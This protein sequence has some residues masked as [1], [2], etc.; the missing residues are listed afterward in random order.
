MPTGSPS[1]RAGP[2]TLSSVFDDA[3]HQLAPGNSASPA[4]AAAT[5]DG[6]LFSGNRHESVPRALFFDRRL[7]PLE[8]NAWQMFR[9]MLDRDGLT[10]FPTYEQLRPWL[11]SMPGAQASHETIARTLTLLRLLNQVQDVEKEIAIVDRLLKLEASTEMVSRF[12]GLTH[13]EIALRRDILGL[14]KRQ[15]RHP[16]LDEAQDSDLWQRWKKLTRERAVQMDDETSVL[17]VAMDLAE[18]TALPLAMVWGAIKSWMAQ[19]LVS[20]HDPR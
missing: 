13:Q 14:P 5:G 10:A 16:V 1:R 15:G 8:R 3:L 19:G 6:F 4:N 12:Y 11:A 7:T 18:D 17:D 9:L 2:A 20:A